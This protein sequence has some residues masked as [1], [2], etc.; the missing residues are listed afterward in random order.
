MISKQMANALSDMVPER[1]AATVS[2]NPDSGSATTVTVVKAWRKPVKSSASTYQGVELTGAEEIINI[3]DRE[4]NP[5][6]NGR[7][8]RPRDTITIGSTV[9]IVQN[10]TLKSVRTRWECLVRRK[11]T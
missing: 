8:I 5:A 11:T 3:L 7:E 2:I 4:L 10:A 1:F 6:V 9:W